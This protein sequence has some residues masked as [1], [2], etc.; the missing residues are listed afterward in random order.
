MY[1]FVKKDYKRLT[2]FFPEPTKLQNLYGSQG[3]V[4]KE[5]AFRIHM[6]DKLYDFSVPINKYSDFYKL[7]KKEIPKAN[8]YVDSGRGE[9][10]F[11]EYLSAIL[12]EKEDSL[13]VEDIVETAGWH[14]VNNKMHYY[15]TADKNCKSGR[16]LANLDMENHMAVFCG[17][18]EILSIADPLI[19]VP[20]FLMAHAGY[21]YQL[22][23][24]ANI[25]VQFVFD[26]VGVTGSRKTSVAKVLYQLFQQNNLFNFMA[27]D[28]A[29]EVV[30]EENRDAMVILDDLSNTANKA[31]VS[32]FEK[33]LRQIG[34]QEGRRRTTDGGQHLNVV[35][36]QCAVVMTAETYIY[37]METSSKLRNIAVFLDKDTIQNDILTRYQKN[38]Y[39]AIH[40]KEP[41]I[42]DKYMTLFIRFVEE[43]YESLVEELIAYE[44]PPL[45][46]KFYRLNESRKVF[47]SIALLVLKM[48][49]TMGMFDDSV[50]AEKFSSWKNII[51][52]VIL[53]NQNLCS[54]TEPYILFLQAIVGK[55][56]RK[57]IQIAVT[58]EV[59]EKCPTAYVGFEDKAKGVIKLEPRK[60]YESVCK[61]YQAS[62]SPFTRSESEIYGVLLSKGVSEGYRDGKRKRLRALKYV[63]IN[64]CKLPFLCLKKSVMESM[65][66][67]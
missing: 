4:K 23:R 10:Y 36:T 62:Q 55:L 1:V 31:H 64:G 24:D 44:L 7:L 3:K 11:S 33:F 48:A 40:N 22:L 13:P 58:R 65:L 26:I 47:H 67:G 45:N 59:Y 57:E 17:G 52:Q 25:P 63:M 12:E 5:I 56:A 32:K 66:G 19:S 61:Y 29:M 6:K 18:W 21:V 16:K 2:N 15:S 60:T 9:S 27:T 51:D 43:N 35:D 53:D 34:D 37:D 41:S 20:L 39:R 38:Q 28:R 8:I 14:M 50:L 42:M 30:T 54:E 46:I 49:G